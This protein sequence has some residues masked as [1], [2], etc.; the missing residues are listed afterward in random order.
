MDDL[1]FFAVCPPGLERYL[2]Q[3]VNSLG[4]ERGKK[5]EGGV[6]MRGPWPEV[7]RANLELRGAVRV[8]V[9]IGFFRAVHFNQLEA[10]AMAFPWADWLRPD[11]PVRVEAATNKSKL[12]HAGAVKG[13]FETALERSLGCEVGT[14]GEVTLKVRIDRNLVTL[15]LDSSGESLHKRGQK[16]FTGKAPLRESLAALLLRACDYDGS[17]PLVD[18]MC[19]SG[20]FLL[21]GAGIAAGLQPGRGRGFAFQSFP[22]F[23]A[24]AFA[25]LIR[26]EPSRP[27][28]AH[29]FG[30]D[31]DQGAIKGA[32]GKASAH[33][34]SDAISFSCQPVSA[35][36]APTRTPGLVMVNPPYGDRIG[37]P[38]SL[39]GLYSALGARLREH[40]GGWRVGIVTTDAKLAHATGL[41]LTSGP[42]IDNGGIKVKLYQ[43]KVGG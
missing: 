18:P 39:I 37:K 41:E 11:V 15:S 40:F 23:E 7:W 43:G 30:Y 2:A 21:E 36:T 19:G 13:R 8:L 26:P 35:L 4:F 28:P 1:D 33:G 32:A 3:E 42:V 24:D 12:Y 22:S 20:T 16:G 25:R 6:T 5:E 31:R 27:A 38:R 17:E 14:H 29:F 9:R 34:L 10:E